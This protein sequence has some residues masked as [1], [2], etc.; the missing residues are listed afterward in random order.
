MP[1]YGAGYHIREAREALGWTQA[2]LAQTLGI[3]PQE[4]S[5]FERGYRRPSR[6]MC[7]RLADALALD[8]ATL[9][10]AAARM[11]TRPYATA[12]RGS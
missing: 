4:V 8:A 6:D 2:T 3:P 12:G 7:L 5:R 11:E 10:L 1:A 9:L